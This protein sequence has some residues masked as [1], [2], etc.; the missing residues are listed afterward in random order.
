MGLNVFIG[1]TEAEL[2]TELRNAQEEL[3]RGAQIV[4]SGS[5]DVNA[6]FLAREAARTRIECLLMALHRLNPDTYPLYEVTRVR[7]TF[8]VMGRQI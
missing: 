5:G 7:K 1:W 6:S 2:A 3:A 4:G 8:A